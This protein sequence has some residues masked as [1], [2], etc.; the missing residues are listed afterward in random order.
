MM[1][2][3]L[4]NLAVNSRDAMPKGGR[5]SIR[6]STVALDGAQTQSMPGIR[7]GSYV[8]LSVADTGDGIAAADLPHIFEPFFTTKEVGQGTGLG[9][10]T[11][12][13]IVKQHG[14]WIEVESQ[15]GV[16]TTFN[17]FL[18]RMPSRAAPKAEDAA[19]ARA[20]RGTETI[21]LVEDESAVRQLMQRLLERH[22]YRVYPAASGVSALEIWRDH[23]GAIDILVT[24]MVMPDGIGGR[25]LA[26]QLLA[27]D[28][29]LKVIYCSG[30]TN[31]IFGPDSPLRKNDNFLEK[32]FQLNR[33]LEM[34]RECADSA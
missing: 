1:E 4:M 28:P 26:D 27:R 31:E 14:G 12:Y 8:R 7:P 6:T 25:E 9:L 18:A 3:V 29:G 33:L 5:L 22:G 30:Y 24:D 19:P 10:A 21:L 32:P 16:G 2:Q 13:G 34:I 11:V 17:I 20:L 15:P 23:G